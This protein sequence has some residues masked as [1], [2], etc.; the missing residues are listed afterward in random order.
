M[1]SILF[2]FALAALM[3]LSSNA[4]SAAGAG[5]GNGNGGH[6]PPPKDDKDPKWPVVS[7][8]DAA[9]SEK[10]VLLL[11]RDEKEKVHRTNKKIQDM[12]D[13]A[14]VKAEVSKFSK[15]EVGESDTHGWK[16]GLGASFPTT[17]DERLLV[18]G[19]KNHQP[20]MVQMFGQD[21]A[22]MKPDALLAAM[23]TAEKMRDSDKVAEK[24]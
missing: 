16:D 20:V 15:D 11:V 23:Q 10:P 12:L 17:G 7:F 2:S 4:W 19:F 6:K 14:G 3:T 24:K 8:T 18:I 22:G 9:K 5:V 13:D 1:K 21:Q